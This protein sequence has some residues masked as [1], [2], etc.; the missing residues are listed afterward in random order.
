MSYSIVF[1]MLPKSLDE[2]K[3]LPQAS[4]K[5]AQD[6]AAL[7]V[8]ALCVYRDDKAECIKMLNYLRGPRPLSPMDEQ[9]LRDRFMD[10]RGYI[11]YSYFEGAVPGN[12]YEPSKPYTLVMDDSHAQIAEDGYKILNLKSGGADS[13]RS[14]TLRNKPS[15][16]EWF[17]WEQMLLAQ[18]RVPAAQ[19]PWA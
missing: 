18:I 13:Q 8:A 9:F 5:N 16:G 6:T 12:G 3:A 15:T 2:L 11:P 4:L 14:I 17:L 10:G 7:C 1:E 19:D